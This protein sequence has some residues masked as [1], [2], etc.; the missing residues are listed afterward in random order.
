MSR[1]VLKQASQLLNGRNAGNPSSLPSQAGSSAIIARATAALS[2]SIRRATPAAPAPRI[3]RVRVPVTCSARGT[4]YT[5]IA[6]RHGEV[7]RFTGFEMPQSGHGTDNAP[8]MPSHLSGQY[9]I[10]WSGWACPVCSTAKGVWLCDCQQMEGAMHCMGTSGGRQHCACGRFEHREFVEIER[11][12]VR[13]S[14]MAAAPKAA[15]ARDTAR[16]SSSTRR[17][18]NG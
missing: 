7:L 11:T 18:T 9:R 10:D 15:G 3:E 13:G 14:S 16:P 1:D 6:E 5:V 12:T 8:R 2:G 17:L 4:A